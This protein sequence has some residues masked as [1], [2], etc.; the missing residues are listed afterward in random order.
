MRRL[1]EPPPERELVVLEVHDQASDRREIGRAV[2]RPVS[3]IVLPHLDVENPM[4]P[5]LDRPVAP[6]GLQ[7]VPGR[8]F[9]AHDAGARLGSGLSFRDAD[10]LDLADRREAG[11]AVRVSSR[12]CPLSD[13]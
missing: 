11:P 5:V 3:K 6:D 4:Q 12:P 10:R 9:P 2:A 13:S 1:Q 8:H 7:E